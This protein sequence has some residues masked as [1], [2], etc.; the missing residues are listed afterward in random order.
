MKVFKKRIPYKTGDEFTVVAFGDCH[1]GDKASDDK[2]FIAML[3]K[4]GKQPNTYF[5][6]MG[7]LHS[8]IPVT[9]KRYEMSNLSEKYWGQQNYIGQMIGDTAAL[10]AEHTTPDQWL[11]TTAGN[12]EAGL[13]KHTNLDPIS[14]MSMALGKEWQPYIF[15]GGYTW[16][17]G[18]IFGHEAGGA[19]R[20]YTIYGNHGWG[21]GSR[22]EGGPI[23]KYSRTVSYYDADLYL[24]GHTHGLWTHAIEGVSPMFETNTPRLTAHDRFVCECGTFLK[25]LSNDENA[26]YSERAGF[27]PKRIGHI[28]IK[29]KPRS[30]SP[31]IGIEIITEG[32]S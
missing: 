22:T 4:H 21:G 23:T 12:H 28:T 18:L 2:A 1:R 19:I 26:T 27:P 7:D 11:V 5:I 16:Y 25:T 10:I 30:D 3:K 17:L 8:Y 24:F 20:K 29:L 32:R 15:N 6:N 14:V 13:T 31:N 9:D